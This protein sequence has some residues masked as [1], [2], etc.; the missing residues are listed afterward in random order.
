MANNTQSA[1]RAK[2]D[3]DK[4]LE[5]VAQLVSLAQSDNEEEARTAAMQ[6]TRMM[7]EHR[8][9]LI[10]EAEIE[11]VKKVVGEAQALARTHEQGGTQKMMLGAVVGFL[12][13]GGK[14]LKL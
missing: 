6:A 7:K 13:G 3:Q 5:R 12:L 9:V 14:G 11:R 8:L 10:P 2:T 4:V 1:E